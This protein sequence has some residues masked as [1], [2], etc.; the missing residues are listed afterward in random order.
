MNHALPSLRVL[1]RSIAV[2]ALALG[3]LASAKD[4][5][6][7]ASRAA[8]E[9]HAKDWFA[10][11]HG[12][13]AAKVQANGRNVQ[14]SYK[15]QFVEKS[16]QCLIRQ[17]SKVTGAGKPDVLNASLYEVTPSAK[18]LLGSVFTVGGKVTHCKVKAQPC[19]SMEAWNT[20]AATLS[21]P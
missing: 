14:S 10:K 8:C 3:G 21:K 19:D 5:A 18:K 12:A 20:A 4:A 1:V 2:S 13:K 9:A 15:A 16:Q 6:A 7:P 17:D 11:A